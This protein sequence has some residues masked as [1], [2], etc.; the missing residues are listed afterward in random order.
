MLPAML[1]PTTEPWAPNEDPNDV[2]HLKLAPGTASGY[3]GVKKN[4]KKWDGRVWVPGK[5]TRVVWH[6][7]WHDDSPKMCAYKILFAY[8]D[9]HT[10]CSNIEILS[11]FH[12][13]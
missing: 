12:G 8:W 5:G 3:K 13:P 6:A 7:W 11:C 10:L 2:L 1:P 9:Q 4:G